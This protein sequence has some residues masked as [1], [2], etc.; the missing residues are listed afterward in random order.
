MW[1]RTYKGMLVTRSRGYR[2][3]SALRHGQRQGFMY[4]VGIR[5]FDSWKEAKQWIDDLAAGTA[6]RN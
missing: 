1:S 6:K 2:F 4:H 5:R 3:G